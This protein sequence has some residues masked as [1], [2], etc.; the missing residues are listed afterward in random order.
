LVV[1]WWRRG[2][3]LRAPSKLCLNVKFVCCNAPNDI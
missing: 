2:R 3:L 1:L